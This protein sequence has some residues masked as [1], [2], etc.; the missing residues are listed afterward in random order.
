MEKIKKEYS[1]IRVDKSDINKLKT[2]AKQL[3]D[4]KGRK[5]SVASLISMLADSYE[6]QM[7]ENTLIND[8]NWM[9]SGVPVILNSDAAKHFRELKYYFPEN[10]TLIVSNFIRET[11]MTQ[12][13]KEIGIEKNDSK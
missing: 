9:I 8:E 2:A 7:D 12:R 13:F 11:A 3:T 1:S 6:T 4:K 10:C 5:I